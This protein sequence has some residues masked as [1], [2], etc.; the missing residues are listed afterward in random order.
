MIRRASYECVGWHKGEQSYDFWNCED[1]RFGTA[2]SGRKPV[3]RTGSQI[4]GYWRSF[5]RKA[6]SFAVALNCGTGSSSLNELVKAFERL[7]M[8]R[9]ENSG[10]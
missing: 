4:S 10:Y 1:V 9:A 7:H 5:S 2:C 6:P 3:T 8:V